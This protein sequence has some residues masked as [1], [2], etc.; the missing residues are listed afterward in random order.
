MALLPQICARRRRRYC[1]SKINTMETFDLWSKTP[2]L[3]EETPTITPYIPENKKSDAAIVIFPGGGYSTRAAHEGEVYAEFLRSNGI[4]AFVVAYRVAPHR[5]PLPLL[6]ARRGVRW[7]RANA[8]KYG[9]DKNKIAVMGSSA[10]GHLAALASSYTH[11]I[12]FEGADCIDSEEFLPNAQILCYPVICAPSDEGITHLGSYKNLIGGTNA[13]LE[14][15]LD[16]SLNVNQ[17]TPPAFIWHTSEDPGVNVINSYRYAEAM[18]KFD[19]RVEMHIFPD[20]RHG[21]GLAPSLPHTAQ[22]T[23]LLI[24]WLSYIEWLK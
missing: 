16:P 6:D 17:S 5:F 12:E 23:G 21:L 13:K 9:I 8:D 7:V 22:W 11:P 15:E 1:R 3:C 2:G 18:R 10:G 4:T 20:G 14:Q 19:I 24:N